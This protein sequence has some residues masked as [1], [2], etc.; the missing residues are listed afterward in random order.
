MLH[1]YRHSLILALLILTAAIFD[2]IFPKF[3]IRI[4]VLPFSHLHSTV[5]TF[6][7]GFLCALPP[8]LVMLS[9]HSS[10]I[11]FPLLH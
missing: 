1:S 3:V 6:V 5:M 7:C 10:S 9:T 11:Y 8:Q 2:K 4:R